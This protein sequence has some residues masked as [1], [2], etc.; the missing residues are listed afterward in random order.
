MSRKGAGLESLGTV[1]ELVP[2]SSPFR[3]GTTGKPK[4]QGLKPFRI[5]GRLQ[6]S[7]GEGTWD[8]WHVSFEDGRY[9]WLAEA[10]GTFWVMRPLPPLR[11]LPPLSSPRS[12]RGSGSTSA[13]MASSP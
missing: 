8:E 11:I 2:T 3:I 10:Q 7:T 13:R 9:A 1:S 6:L 12:R 5:V 4:T